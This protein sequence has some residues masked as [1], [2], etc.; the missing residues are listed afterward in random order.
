MTEQPPNL[1]KLILEHTLDHWNS[2]IIS[3]YALSKQTEYSAVRLGGKVT[4]LDGIFEWGV[5]PRVP[6]VYSWVSMADVERKLSEHDNNC[7][8]CEQCGS[9]KKYIIG[10]TPA[11]EPSMWVCPNERCGYD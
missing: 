8:H 11:G 3:M 7:P 9:P 5:S 1:K 2:D 10:Y 4:E 6:W